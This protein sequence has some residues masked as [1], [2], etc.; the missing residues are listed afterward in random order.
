LCST[1]H[2]FSIPSAA[3][4]SL[5]AHGVSQAIVISGESGSGKTEAT[6]KCLQYL[7]FVGS[8]TDVR[9]GNDV[10]RCVALPLHRCCDC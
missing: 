8:S 6:K 9:G 7:S 5:M 10:S 4:K 3:Y 2:L 1:P